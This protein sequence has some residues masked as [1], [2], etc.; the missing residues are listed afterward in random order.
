MPIY[1][2][3]AKVPTKGCIMC[4]CSFEY[5]QGISEVPLPHCPSCGEKVK[6]IIS[7]CH[8]AIIE[9]HNQH[10]TCIEKKIAKYEQEGFYS[11]AA[12]LAEKYSNRVKDNILNERALENYKKAGYRID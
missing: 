7:W 4:R 6:R 10:H 9:S 2:Y 12:E 8:A 1:E 11:H 3:I 5:I